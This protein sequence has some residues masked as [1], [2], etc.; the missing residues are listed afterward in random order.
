MKKTILL[1]TLLFSAALVQG[2]TLRTGDARLDITLKGHGRK[3]ARCTIDGQQ[4]PE[5]FVPAAASGR[6]K[7]EIELE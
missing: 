6:M 3:V 5:A 1:L 2:Q 7:I 4:T